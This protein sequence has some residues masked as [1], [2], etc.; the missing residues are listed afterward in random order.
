MRCLEKMSQWQR[1][2]LQPGETEAEHDQVSPHRA[3]SLHLPVFQ[4]LDRI[5]KLRIKWPPANNTGEWQIFDDDMCEILQATSRGG[6]DKKLSALTTII[7]C[8]ASKR[9][10]RVVVRQKNDPYNKNRRDNQIKNICQEFRALKKQ[11]KRSSNEDKLPLAE[12]RHVLWRKHK[13]IRRAEWHRRR[14]E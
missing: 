10:G 12:L 11:Q 8:F 3:Q 4:S 14:G 5:I 1:T 2:R 13:H 7:T 9:F 6:V